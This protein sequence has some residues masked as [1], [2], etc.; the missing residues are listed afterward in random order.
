MELEKARLEGRVD[1]RREIVVILRDMAREG[2]RSKGEGRV[3]VSISFN[4]IVREERKEKEITVVTGTRREPVKAPNVV[5]IRK[6][7]K[8]SEEVRNSGGGRIEGGSE[9]DDGK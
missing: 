9:K 2:S 6:D 5:I 4:Q 1:E 8:E 7:G 3:K